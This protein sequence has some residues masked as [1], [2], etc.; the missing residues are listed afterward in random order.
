MLVIQ[1]LSSR[2]RGPIH[3]ACSTRASSSKAGWMILRGLVA[4]CCGLMSHLISLSHLNV[5]GRTGTQYPYF[6]TLQKVPLTHPFR[7]SPH[8]SVLTSHQP[9]GPQSPCFPPGICAQSGH[10]LQLPGASL[11]SPFTSIPRLLH[12]PGSQGN[13]LL[14]CSEAFFFF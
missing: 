11:Q 8:L 9:R 14:P 13:M 1:S 5:V 6:S 2:G 4:G 7:V 12:S 10:S 3:R